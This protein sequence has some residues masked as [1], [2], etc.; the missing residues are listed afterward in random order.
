MQEAL[1][2]LN[3]LEFTLMKNNSCYV[4]SDNDYSIGDNSHHIKRAT[5]A[6]TGFKIFPSS[7][8]IESATISLYGI[9]Q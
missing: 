9:K 5:T 6:Y 4:Y 8:N 3:V 7:A 2:I 1:K